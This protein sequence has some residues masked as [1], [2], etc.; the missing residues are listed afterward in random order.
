MA[1]FIAKNIYIPLTN[2]LKNLNIEK[3]LNHLEETQWYSPDKIKELQWN[4]LIKVLKH[5]SDNIPFYR[6]RVNYANIKNYKDFLNV[7]VLTKNDVRGNK[8]SLIDKGY[9]N[10]IFTGRTSGSTGISIEF[11]TDVNYENYDI[12][13]RWRSRKWF[14]IN[15]GDRQVAIWGRPISSSIEKSTGS[16][17]ARLQNM[18][19]ISAFD[20]SEDK[21]EII[22]RNIIKY[23]PRFFYGYATALEKLAEYARGSKVNIKSQ[24]KAVITTAETLTEN[25]RILIKEV[26]NCPVAIEYGCSEIGGFA[27]ECPN[28]NL[29]ISS[30]N[31]FVEFLKKGQPVPEGETGEIVVTSLTNCY[32][33]FIRYNI[34]DMGSYK[35]GNCSCGRNLP[36][37]ELNVTK[38]IEMIKTKNG[39]LFSSE[40][41][42]YINLALIK[43]DIKGIKQFKVY[44]YKLDEFLVQVVKDDVFSEEAV[45]YFVQKMKE[46]IG[47][48]IK[49]NVE[50][51]TDILREETGKLRYF[52]SKIEDNVSMNSFKRNKDNWV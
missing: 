1:D 4:N 2:K 46:F 37:M 41:F 31:V 30:E 17:K 52:V 47:A 49:V 10:R 40:L 25:A 44:Q 9:K 50:F 21:M 8:G 12:A 22:L 13:S 23:K 24:L 28:G 14:G 27:Y 32:M 3:T 11:Y 6:N 42:D 35:S 34:G 43:K 18:L 51:A 45:N 20:L 26:F 16:L 38:K 29:H 19:L 5:S 39:N 36:L 48:N 7:P 33:P 15:H